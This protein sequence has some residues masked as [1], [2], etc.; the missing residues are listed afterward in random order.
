MAPN[1][2]TAPM[3]AAALL[4]RL[5]RHYIEP[6]RRLPGGIF[7][8][9]VGMN[10]GYGAGRRCDAVYVGFTTTSGR[11][12]IGHEIKVSRSDWVA[13]LGR[14]TGKADTWADQCHQWWL[15][16]SD[17]S[18][19]RDGELPEGWGLMSPGRSVTRM[20]IHR[21]AVP[22]VDHDPSWE[23]VRSVFARYDT[24]RAEALNAGDK[25]ALAAATVKANAEADAALARR[26]AELPDV[27]ELQQRLALLKQV[28]G[29]PIDWNSA[30]KPPRSGAIGL[31]ALGEIAALVSAHGSVARV[32][33]R[34]TVGY[35][36]PVAAASKAIADLSAAL[37]GVQAAGGVGDESRSAA[38]RVEALV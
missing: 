5:R 11:Q 21:P 22:K 6:S 34:I 30:D 9:E 7:V 24:L 32:A 19:V 15:V 38:T 23:V 28:L 10:G 12:L 26:I 8:P 35:A 17:P 4:G 33:H 13:E 29:A 37:A 20:T 18:I 1:R 2:E 31:Q 16:V 3:T 25:A 14:K 27:S 36:N